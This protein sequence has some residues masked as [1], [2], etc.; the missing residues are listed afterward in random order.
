[1]KTAKLFK[2]M[3]QLVNKYVE[4]WK[5]DLVIDKKTIKENPSETTYYWYLRQCG[6]QLLS[7][8]DLE[9]LDTGVPASAEFWLSS[10]KV[11]YKID[12]TAQTLK[13]ITS[14][15]IKDLIDKAKPMPETLKLDYLVKWMS[16]KE[17]QSI[18]RPWEILYHNIRWIKFSHYRI[19]NLINKGAKIKE[20]LETLNEL[21]NASKAS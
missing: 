2:D 18:E 6:T 8:S 5:T 7:S 4:A 11:I 10:A 21:L 17:F 12:F 19:D 9:Y 20:I 16:K 3:E 1:M 14:K 15:N 13:L